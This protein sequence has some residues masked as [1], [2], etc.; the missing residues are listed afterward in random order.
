MGKYLKKISLIFVALAMIISTTSISIFAEDIKER[1]TNE[2]Y[3]VVN[4]KTNYMGYYKNGDLIKEF[5][6]STGTRKA[7]TPNGKHKI[8]NRIVNRPYYTGGIPGGSPNNPLGNRWMGLHVGSTYGTTYGVHGNNNE[9]SIGKNV[10][11]GCIRMHNNDIR[12]L[13]DQVPTGAYVIVDNSDKSYIEIATKYGVKLKDPN[14]ITQNIKNLEA[15]FNKFSI[16]NNKIKLLDKNSYITNSNDATKIL[17]TKNN[18]LNAYNKLTSKEKSH[19]QV[20]NIHSNY[21]KIVNIVEGAEAVLKFYE[22]V[23]AQSKDLINNSKAAASIN[24]VNSQNL[25]TRGKAQKEFNEAIAYE[26]ISGSNRMIYLNNQYTDTINFLEISQA[27]GSKDINTAKSKASK[28]KDGNYK[29]LVNNAISAFSDLDNHWAEDSIKEAMNAGWVDLSKI[30]R[31]DASITRAEFVKIINRAFGFTEQGEVNL[32]DVDKSMWYYNEVSIAISKGYINGY[33]DNTFRPND[34][35][36]REEVAKIIS[37]IMNNV[38]EDIDKI[39][40]YK[41]FNEVSEWALSYVEGVV[42]AGYMGN[43]GIDFRPKENITRAE[44][45]VTI[46]RTR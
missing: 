9:N 3:L 8:V 41:D 10:T 1:A 16:Y 45:V 23:T 32:N 6:V 28:I 40:K 31:P 12:W 43:G 42:E 22:N 30:F 36:T 14:A 11:G 44:S 21:T 15:E 19:P 38:D 35:I 25:G 20:K 27:L 46:Q 34:N 24:N 5:R 2:V 7:P 33:D 37:S 17:E 26:G 4:S 13:F 29:L 18:Y 39:S